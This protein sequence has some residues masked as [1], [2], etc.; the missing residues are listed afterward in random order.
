MFATILILVMH[1]NIKEALSNRPDVR[2]LTYI[3]LPLLLLLIFLGP[4][5]NRT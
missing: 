3:P 1:E 4:K 2:E 5:A